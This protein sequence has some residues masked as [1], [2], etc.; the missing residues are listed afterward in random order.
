MRLEKKLPASLLRVGCSIALLLLLLLLFVF[1]LNRPHVPAHSGAPAR[2]DAH[3]PA[4]DRTAR[5]PDL[6]WLGGLPS[7]AADKPDAPR[8]LAEDIAALTATRQPADALTAYQMIDGCEALRPVFDIDPMPAELLTRKQQCAA[9]TDAMRRAQYDYLR[10][11]AF[12]GVPGVGS[13]WIRYGPSGDKDALRTKRDD[14]S[15]I[16]WKRQAMALVIRDG[17]E[18]DFNAL[19]DLMNGYAGKGLV[20]DADPTRALAY[21]TAY[22]EVVDLMQVGPIQNQPTDAELGAMAAKLSPDQ[23]AWAQAKAAAIVAARRKRA[24]AAV[25][26]HNEPQ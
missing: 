9:I 12:A 5:R 25:Q 19:Q 17:D 16:E 24:A 7:G 2:I 4:A 26:I 1:V 3:H 8:S 21:A 20:F 13:A 14:P 10:A 18:G 15:V 6:Q 11:A 23:V 22:K